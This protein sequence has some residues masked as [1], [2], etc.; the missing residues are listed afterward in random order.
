MTW[1]AR[2]PKAWAYFSPLHAFWGCQT[3]LT[4]LEPILKAQD[5]CHFLIVY[6]QKLRFLEV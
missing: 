2:A 5:T 3:P 4:K 1:H 6:K